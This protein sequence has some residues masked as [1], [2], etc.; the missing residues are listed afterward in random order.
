MNPCQVIGLVFLTTLL[1]V[2]ERMFNLA[3][4]LLSPA[5]GFLDRWLPC[6]FMPYIVGAALSTLPTGAQLVK[7][8]AFIVSSFVL[9]SL[10][11]CAS[12]DRRDVTIVTCFCQGLHSREHAP[13]HTGDSVTLFSCVPVADARH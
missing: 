6:I 9:V 1:F 10:P 11:P 2:S 13:Y 5:V 8:L 7:A 3:T 12:S 4:R